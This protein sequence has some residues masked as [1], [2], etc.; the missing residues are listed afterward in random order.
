MRF[1]ETIGDEESESA[2]LKR[3]T[4]NK[5]ATYALESARIYAKKSALL[6]DIQLRVAD[7]ALRSILKRIVDC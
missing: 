3:L 2:F 7:P 5:V 1:E 4:A 6:W